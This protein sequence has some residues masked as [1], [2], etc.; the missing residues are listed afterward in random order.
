MAKAQ[1]KFELHLLVKGGFRHVA[2]YFLNCIP[3]LHVMNEL[4]A[5]SPWYKDSKT[6]LELFRVYVVQM[7]CLI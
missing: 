4:P 5:I 1:K 7:L 3:L 6:G 2:H